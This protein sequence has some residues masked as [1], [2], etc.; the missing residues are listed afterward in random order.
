MNLKNVHRRFLFL[1][2]FILI[3]CSDLSILMKVQ[4]SIMLV[5]QSPLEVH[6]KI[7][8]ICLGEASVKSGIHVN[9]VAFSASVQDYLRTS[10]YSQ[11]ELAGELGLH[12]KVLSRKLHGSGNAHF[13]H[14]EVRDIVTTLARWCVITTQDEALHLLALAQLE[15]GIFSPDEWQAPPLGTLAKKQVQPISSVGSGFP[16]YNLQHNLPSPTTRLIGREWAVARLL[17]LLERDDVRLV[18]LIGPGGSGKTRLA[19]H[20]AGQLVGTFAQGVWFVPLAGVSDPALVPVSIIQAL[21]MKSSPSLPPLQSLITYLRNKQ[22]L[23]VLDNFEQIGEATGVVDDL[24]AAVPGLKVLVTSRSVLHLYG[25]H[26]FSVPPLDVPDPSI[27]LDATELLHFSSIQLFI[28]RAQA[29]LPDFALTNRN[30]AVI[31]QICARVDGLPL[32]LELAAARVKV[33]PPALLLERLSQARLLMLTGGPRNLPS[34]Q[35]TLRDTITWSYDLLSSTEQASFRRLG[36]FTGGWSIKAAEA[37]M[38]AVTADQRDISVSHSPLDILEQ[39][40]DNSLVVCL[41]DAHGRARF[42]MLETL[43]EYALE[44]LAAE[45]E[46]ERL[47]DWHACYYLKKAEAAELG[48]RGP[49]QLEWLARLTTDRDNFS[50]ALE[51]SLQRAR[52]GMRISAFSFLGQESPGE[53]KRVAGSSTLSVQGDP[54]AGLLAVELSLRLAAAFRHYWEWQGDLT[55]ARRWLGAALELPLAHVAGETVQAARA[56]ALS[57]FSRLTCLQNDQTRAVELAEES[58]ALCRQPDDP[59][60]Y[61]QLLLYLADA[62]GFTFDFEQMHSFYTQSRELFEQIGDRSAVADLLKDQ[63]GMSILESRYEESIDCLLKSIQLCYK[64]DHRQYMTTGMCILSTAVGMREKPDPVQASLYSAQLEGAA[65]SLMDTIGLTSWTKNS[66]FISMVYQ[67]IRS[68]VDE[69]SWEAAYT[70]GRALTVEQAID[71]ANQLR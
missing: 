71:L 15:P 66:P 60:L 6:S 70:A 25:E 17:Q 64:L 13:T 23:L 39:L 48:L 22:L 42:T 20:V 55:E 43:R 51:W 40:V 21:G 50:A 30:A 35:Q 2:Y 33:L 38:Q 32:A 28:E 46:S 24:L 1:P 37:M 68:R 7:N 34:R 45:G 56:K 14:L 41:P 52:D 58:I 57:E 59:W 31:A 53:N 49:Q 26:E 10:G 5:T 62:A 16:A 63:G 4:L 36:V 29:V 19:L 3:C 11:K 18:T 67:H 8:R 9:I 61:G 27:A 65:D 44:R 47:R 54:G 69:Q 12:P